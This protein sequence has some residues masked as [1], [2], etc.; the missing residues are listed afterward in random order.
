MCKLIDEKSGSDIVAY[1][2]SQEAAFT[3]FFIIAT[4]TSRP[5]LKQLREE[6]HKM[7]KEKYRELPYSTEGEPDSGWI[8]MDYKDIFVHFF[9]SEKREYFDIEKI[10]GVCR[11]VKI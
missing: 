9:L 11:K 1:D 8:I 3:D 2:I 6:T 10:W 4:A 7:M 5:H